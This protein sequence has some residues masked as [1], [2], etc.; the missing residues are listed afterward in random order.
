VSRA[1][2][3][4]AIALSACAAAATVL[5]LAAPAF[6]GVASPET[7][8]STP[9]AGIDDIYRFVLGVLVTIF[10]LVGGFMLY[11]SLRFR[12]KGDDPDAEE[13]PQMHGS[14]RLEIGW[15]LVPILILVAIC[16]YTFAKLPQVEDVPKG[17]ETVHISAFSFGWEFTYPNGKKQESDTL[18]LPVGKPTRLLLTA[19]TDDVQHAFWVW[20]MGPKRDA[21]PGRVNQF[22]YEPTRTGTY[23]GQC[24]E[25]CGVG[26]ATMAIKVKVVSQ[27]EFDRFLAGLK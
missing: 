3:R 24:A 17:A 2:R 15:T 10:V 18:M 21:I 20:Q 4:L 8:R 1:H 11:T 25:F 27:D 13:P 19:R 16:G 23:R 26:H 7:P 9:A 5:V 14:N 22:W 12:D 6:A